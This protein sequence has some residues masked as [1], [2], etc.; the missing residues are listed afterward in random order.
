MIGILSSFFP[1]PFSLGSTFSTIAMRI[2]A[3]F[4]IISILLV[5]KVACLAMSFSVV[6]PRNTIAAQNIRSLGHSFKMVRVYALTISAKM[7]NSQSFVYR[8]TKS[9]I[10][11]SMNKSVP[12]SSV[13]MGANRP[14]PFPARVYIPHGVQI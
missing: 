13:P 3:S 11:K 1:F 12:N 9:F 10:H 6:N 8:A 4:N 5:K 14:T 7:I 2:S